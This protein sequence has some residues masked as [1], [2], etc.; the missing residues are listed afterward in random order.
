MRVGL[1]LRAI[2]A[3]LSLLLVATPAVSD[4]RV[5]LVIGNSDYG[6]EV[7]RLKNP[8]NDARLLASTLEALGFSVDLV[9]DADQKAMKRAVMQ[10]G[11]KLRETGADGIGLFYYAGH[12]LQVGGENFLVPLGAQ[13]EAEGDVEI[14]AVSAGAI[15]SQMQYA[16]NSVNLV[17]LDA[18]RNNPLSRSFRS[19][20]RG[21][22]RVDAPR[23][24]FVGYATAPG[25][26]AADGD[27]ANSPYAL[28]LAEELGRPGVSVDTAHRAVRAKVLE[29]TGKRQTPWDSSSLTAEVI[30]A[31][32]TPEAPA[33]PDNNSQ[34][35]ELL[36]W[37]SVM[38]SGNPEII[39]SYLVAYPDGTFAGLAR[40]K[41]KEL[42]VGVSSSN[43]TDDELAPSDAQVASMSPPAPVLEVE[44][45]DAT[46]VAKQSAN[47]RAE[48][49]TEAKVLDRL[50]EDDAVSV[51]GKVKGKDWLRV[52]VKAQTGYVSSKLLAE[53]D[54]EEISAWA[55]LKKKPDREAI[56]AF[57]KQHP[58]GYFKMKAEAL[59]AALIPPAAIGAMKEGSATPPP[60]IEVPATPGKPPAP[61]PDQ[62]ARP[63]HPGWSVDARSG[64]WLWNSVPQLDEIVTWSGKCGA[65][66]PATGQGVMEWVVGGK[67]YGRYEGE[68][69]G[70]KA[71]GRGTSVWANGDRYEG[72]WKDHLRHGHGTK[73]WA[74]G[75]RYE[76]EWKD[77]ERN[78]RGTMVWL[79]GHRYEGEW[80]DDER[81]GR[82]T[83][84]DADGGRYEGE[85][86]DDERNGRGTMVDAD[87][88]RYEGEWKDDE[89]I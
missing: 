40:A 11:A 49:S 44:E 34:Q 37:E 42:K 88:G 9:L 67:F 27:G 14:E 20:E 8:V 15:L 46:Y 17:F 60:R 86:K 55:K 21:L 6:D 54:A 56:T 77:D 10:F 22:A 79:I 7:G 51:T 63:G 41:L 3:G 30:L 28:A 5:A 38:N 83:M 23:G 84:V 70:G 65:D 36:F 13:I 74:S 1:I 45:L 50:K 73:V 89:R 85:W 19:G 64:C 4:G 78:G 47:V 75:D 33:A 68:L 59:L 31:S 58:A 12:G 29:A 35:A 48:P 76:G 52:S 16:G 87:G 62:L 81:N 69:R 2:F 66:G 57:L 24:S 80:K 72:E 39:D 32:L 43:T 71:N 18:C 25:E 53:A 61:P 82:G 26:V